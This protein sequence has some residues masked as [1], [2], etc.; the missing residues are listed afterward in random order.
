MI[1]RV[2]L[3]RLDNGDFPSSLRIPEYWVR[4]PRYAPNSCR[5]RPEP[6]P[7]RRWPVACCTNGC[8]TIHH[9]RVPSASRE[10]IMRRAAKSI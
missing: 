9:H 6:D 2:L 5:W 4:M 10:S 7:G 1:D 8:T 3:E